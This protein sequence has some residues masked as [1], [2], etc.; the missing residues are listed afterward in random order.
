MSALSLLCIRVVD[1]LHVSRGF[2]L[3][4]RVECAWDARRLGLE[5]WGAY[6]VAHTVRK[7]DGP[8]SFQAFGPTPHAALKKLIAIVEKAEP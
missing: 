2:M 7:S 4:H 5:R 1:I 8:R 3:P 6:V